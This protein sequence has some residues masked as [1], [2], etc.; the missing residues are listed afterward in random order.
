MET[1]IQ[2]AEVRVHEPRW[3]PIKSTRAWM[4]CLKINE[5]S[6][7]FE[8]VKLFSQSFGAIG[9]SPGGYE[10]RL[11][12]KRSWVRI[13]ASY[14]GWT[15]HFFTL[16]CCKKV[17]CLKR[18]KINGKEAGVGPFFKWSIVG[19]RCGAVGRA[20]ASNTRDLLFESSHW[21][22]NSLSTALKNRIDKTKIK[23]KG[24]SIAHV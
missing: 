5:R 22:F 24:P 23:R 2:L 6:G 1:C 13:P 11:M 12:F 7:L 9:G 15:W 10:R 16:I 14:T 21:Q 18:L 20:V 3:P 8:N 19:Q 4:G 17:V